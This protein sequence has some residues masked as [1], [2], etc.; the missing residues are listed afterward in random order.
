MSVDRDK[1]NV[2][3]LE[4]WV[5]A[6][7]Q[8]ARSAKCT[9]VGLIGGSRLGIDRRVTDMLAKN[10][11][12][13]LQLI[14]AQMRLLVVRLTVEETTLPLL[15]QTAE[16]EQFPAISAS[17]LGR[18]SFVDVPMLLGNAAPWALEQ[19]PKRLP[20]W[21]ESFEVILLDL[22]AMHLVTSRAVGRLCDGCYVVLGPDS[23]AS[24]D[25]ILQHIAWHERSGAQVIGSLVSRFEQAAA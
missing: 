14:Q 6:I 7:S 15:R 13:G 4:K 22:G 12:Q 25:W 23:C 3:G 17:P 21:K 19:L 2:L 16:K 20:E 11:S 10:L 9:T 18:W 8:E 5:A 24:P 1:Q